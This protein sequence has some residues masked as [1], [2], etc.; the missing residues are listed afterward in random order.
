MNTC[1]SNNTA[2]RIDSLD[3]SLFSSIASETSEEDRK[4]LLLL[5]RCVRSSGQPYVYL[6]IGSH[7]GGTIQPHLQDT[8]CSRIYSIDSRPESL[9]DI[10]GDQIGYDGN[11]TQRMMDGL[12]EA[13]PGSDLKRIRTF[14]C[15]ASRIQPCDI[16]ER[17]DLC[18]I[19]GEHTNKAVI[20]DFAAC[21]RLAKPSAIIAF[22]DACLVYSGIRSIKTSLLRTS[23]PFRGI[24]LTGCVYTILI[25]A[26]TD[27]APQLEPY[28]QD[29]D[30]YFHASARVLWKKRMTSKHP[31][32]YQI[33]R[34]AKHSV[35]GRKP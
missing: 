30:N 9:P 4:A 32:L 20:S 29:E 12:R 22:H 14:D 19:D 7:L 33:Y 15:D 1:A 11:S 2:A 21:Q 5:Q 6:E 25:G 10:R 3:T 28:S 27:Y 34:K 17:A 24:M 35:F 31:L 8:A 16:Q 23:T 18:L 26:S 13:Y